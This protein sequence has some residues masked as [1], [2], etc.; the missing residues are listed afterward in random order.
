M[1]GM[2]G[3]SELFDLSGRAAVV[4][5]A[6]SGLGRAIAVKLASAGATVCCADIALEQAH[7]TAD[8]IVQVG[9]LAEAV[10]LDVA[11][12]VE[13]D[14]AV[15]EFVDRTGRLDVM[16]NIAGIPGDR[17][18]VIDIEESAFDCV[19]AIHFKGVL[20]G[21]QA[22]ARAMIPAG[23]GTIVNMASSA[24][25]TPGPTL[26]SYSVAKAAIAQLTKVLASELGQFDIR[27]NAIAPGYV[28]TPLSLDRFT[29]NAGIAEEERAVMRKRMVEM[30]ALPRLGLP[31]DVANQVLYLASDAASFVT[32]QTL[33]IN[34]GASMPW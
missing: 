21:S 25:D 10:Q 16:C 12:R 34:G 9:G 23:R 30:S 28:E 11:H 22:A 1:A 5:G 2:P 18:L 6:G 7:Q 17:A 19:F 29:S 4:T 14:R 13:V 26:G 32:G 8:G 24:I 20:F 33:R 3:V 27:V 15:G 31:E